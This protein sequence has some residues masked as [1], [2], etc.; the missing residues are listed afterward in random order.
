MRQLRTNL[1]QETRPLIQDKPWYTYREAAARVNRSPITIKRWRRGGMPMSFDNQG[2]RIVKHHT[3]LE[4]LRTSIE[5]NDAN[6]K[7]KSDTPIF[8]EDLLYLP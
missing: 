2:R 3:L 7:K 6:R 4:Q 8:A 1:D 5:R